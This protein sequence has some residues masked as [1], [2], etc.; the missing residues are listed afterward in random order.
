MSK[1]GVVIQTMMEMEA[2]V[3]LAM[4]ID[5]DSALAVLAAPDCGLAL[6]GYHICSW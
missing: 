3:L 1:G 5:D 6:V 4:P 2:L